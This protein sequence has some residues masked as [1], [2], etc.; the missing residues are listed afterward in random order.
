[1]KTYGVKI[2]VLGAII[3]T[4]INNGIETDISEMTLPMAILIKA[5][6]DNA[7]ECCEKLYGKIE[8]PKN[9]QEEM[10]RNIKIQN[11]FIENTIFGKIEEKI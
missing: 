1:M 7:I 2:S 6:L 9:I 8:L 3:I 4:E 10:K 11:K 5:Y